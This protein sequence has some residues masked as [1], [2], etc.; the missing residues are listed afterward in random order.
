MNI[1][2]LNK[3][4]QFAIDEHVLAAKGLESSSAL[5]WGQ[6][7]WGRGDLTNEVIESEGGRD[8]RVVC[9]SSCCIAGNVIAQ[10]G[11]KFVVDAEAYAR[12]AP[13]QTISA[14]NCVTKDG[15]LYEV[16]RRAM[17]LL[18]VDDVNTDEGDLFDGDSEIW[19]VIRMA[20]ALAVEHGES[21][22]VNTT[23]LDAL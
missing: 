18:D 4:V 7:H 22:T 23:A 12:I 13:G 6:Q 17:V 19:D 8:V 11:D 2:R 9:A 5:T 15:I 16:P 21:L 14:D 10:A 3:A 1:D 20:Q